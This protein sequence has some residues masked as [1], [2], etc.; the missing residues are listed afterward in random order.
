[1]E[2]DYL[3]HHPE[4]VRQIA[5][6]FF[7]EWSYLYPG[8]TLR[9]FED[10]IRRRARMDKLPLAL[11]AIE[12]GTVIGTISLKIQDMDNR[13]ELEPWLAGLYVSWE[14]RSKGVGTRLVEA[15][16][17]MACEMGIRKL[18]LYTPKS[19]NFY[20]KLGWRVRERTSYRGAAVVLMEKDIVHVD[21]P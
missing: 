5:D 14:W 19:E 4:A 3:A 10:L 7:E 6:W 21:A 20:L 2:I 9:D 12:S 13:T 18:F 17:K 1:M 16:E 11:V 8:R 15:V